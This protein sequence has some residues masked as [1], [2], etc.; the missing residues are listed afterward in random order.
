[1]IERRALRPIFPAIWLSARA[2]WLLLALSLV[3]ALASVVPALLY[4][5]YG[6]AAL[7]LALLA[8]DAASGPAPARLRVERLPLG[9][10]A[11]RRPGHIVYAVENGAAIPIRLGLIEAPLPTL[12]L[13]RD[14]LEARVAARSR[15]TLSLAF[16]PR[17]RGPLAFGKLYL[18]VE[19]RIGL[20]RRRYAVDARQN[21][22]V[23]PDLAAVEGYGRL[24]R[25]NTLLEAGLRK[26]R[27]RGVGSEF[28]SLREY[29]PGDAFRSVDWK[30]TARRGRMMVAQ[31]EV[32]RSQQVLVVFDCGRLMTPRIGAQRK[33]D[34][35]LTAGLS[36]ARVAQSADD[37]VGLLAFAAQPLL[38]IAPRR[39]AAHY[40]ALAQAAYDLQPR[41]EEPD[42][43]TVFSRLKQRYTKRSLI[44]LFTDMFDPVASA[45]VLGGLARL[46]TR[47][48][49]MCVLMNDRAIASALDVEPRTVSAAYRTSVAMTLADE[50]ARAIATLRAGGVIVI[51]RPAPALN[52][53]I[54]DAYLDVKARGLL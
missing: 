10:I 53:A 15:A 40:H 8:A 11:L 52:V 43:E 2:V 49:V 5:V 35:A 29:L 1:M 36:V 33:F 6:G 17:E 45:A 54:L 51:D 4:A 27:L 30:A 22:R 50:R 37:Q 19:N 24:A 21:A 26:L 34:Y 47:H 41:L 20:L 32:E 13:E 42:Y 46:T 48:L 14:V 7:L 16:L 44:V 38:S 28:E 39:G 18:W 3:L 25:R 23:F 9:F 12:D 31:Y